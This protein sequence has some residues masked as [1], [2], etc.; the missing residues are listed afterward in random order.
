MHVSRKTHVGFQTRK[1]FATPCHYYITL[2]LP[3]VDG[4]QLNGG[5]A[6]GVRCLCVRLCVCKGGGRVTLINKLAK[7]GKDS[8]DERHEIGLQVSGECAQQSQQG[9]QGEGRPH[10]EPLQQGV[11]N[12]P[13]SSISRFRPWRWTTQALFATSA[14][15]KTCFQDKAKKNGVQE[16]TFPKFMCAPS[17]HGAQSV[18][19]S[20][21]PRFGACPEEK[22]TLL[23]PE[24][25]V[26]R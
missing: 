21:D 14:C 17:Q 7:A 4:T 20:A 25:S 2:A 16:D 23:A 22:R 11:Q 13:L 5:W 24:D 9:L 1:Y 19:V 26:S 18:T 10:V 6:Q 8:G 3:R 15:R 12:V